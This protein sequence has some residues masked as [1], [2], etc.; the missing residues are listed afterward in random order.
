MHYIAGTEIVVNTPRSKPIR[1][2]MSSAQIRAVSSGTAS[3]FEEQKSK[4]VSGERYVLVRAYIKEQQVC[5]V[6]DGLPGRVEVLFDNV[7][8]GDK[9]ISKVKNEQIPDYEQIHLNK[10]D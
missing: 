4:F 2:G 1:P 5:Y 3:G 8:Q 6:F 10:S 9:F 7:G